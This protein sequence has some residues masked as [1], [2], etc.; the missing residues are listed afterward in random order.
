MAN[1]FSRKLDLVL[2]ALSLSRVELAAELGVDKSAAGRW[3]T[4]A[5]EPTGYNLARL[6]AAIARRAPGFNALDWE[7]EPDAL[8]QRLG[9]DP[10]PDLAAAVGAL[11]GLPL[12]ILDQARSTTDLR[13]EA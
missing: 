10:S 8:A 1:A 13:A 7:R 12:A 11:A 6:T 4:G 9:A 3:L 2:K 5:A